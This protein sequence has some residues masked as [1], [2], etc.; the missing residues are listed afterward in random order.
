MD[1]SHS[2]IGLVYAFKAN[3]IDK[4]VRICINLLP[5]QTL[6]GYGTEA[7]TLFCNYPFKIFGFRIIYAEIMEYNSNS[8]RLA[9][10][11]GLVEEAYS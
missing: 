7:G 2:T 6:K 9:Q 4:P 10:K 8:L 11:C 1:D 5:E 3:H